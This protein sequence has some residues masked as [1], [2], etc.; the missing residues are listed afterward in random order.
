M[1]RR[2]ANLGRI[3]CPPLHIN[4][5]GRHDF[6]VVASDGMRFNLSRA[7]L[8][9]TSS[10]FADMLTVGEPSSSTQSSEE[11]TVNASENYLVLDALFAISYSHPEK[12][13]PN[14]VM[15]AQ[16]AEL[17]RVAEKYSM[18]HALDYLSSHLML[19]RTQGTTTIQPFTVTHPLPTLSIS[20]THGFSLPARLALKEVVNATNSIW[21]TALDD[22]QLDNFTLDFRT[23]KKIHKMRNSRA[24]AYKGFIKNLQSHSHNPNSMFVQDPYSR[25]SSCATC[26][27]CIQDWRTDLLKKFEETPNSGAFRVAFY[28]GWTCNKC[29]QGL[30]SQNRSAFETFITLQAA[31]ECKLPELR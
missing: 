17:I 3:N 29:G 26:A 4:Y 11:Q 14:I 5:P 24:D 20:L 23:L 21:D 30:I 16:I 6:V 22:A 28:K 31:E 15:F 10:F 25:N 13:K 18:H 7:V 12:P 2:A 27:T 19:P 8:A 9:T 1:S